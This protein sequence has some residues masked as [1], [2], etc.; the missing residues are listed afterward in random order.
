MADIIINEISQNYTYQIGNSSFC[1]VALPITACW[2]PA[3]ED[4]ASVG[5]SL[6]DELELTQWQKFTA[7]PDGLNSF[8]KTFRGPA[9]NY[10]IAKDF[11]Y[12][13]AMTLLTA[14]YDVLVCR[15]CPGTHAQVTLTDSV[16]EGTFTI[17]AKYPGTFGN[18]LFV[19]L[20]K[21]PNKNYWNLVTYVVD[22]SGARTSAENLTFAFD[23][24][25][26]T[27][28]IMHISEL[29]SSFFTFVV[30][31]N[32]TDAASFAGADTGVV[33]TGGTDRS[34]D[35]TAE[36]MMSNA[37]GLAT[38]R[39]ATVSPTAGTDYIAALNALKATNPDIAKAATVR[40]MEWV[41]TNAI[42]VYKLLDDRL[43]YNPNRIISP[44]WDDQNITEID[45]STPSRISAV[46]PLHAVLLEMS[47][48]SR[49]GA[50]YIDIPKSCPRSAVY[51]ETGDTATAGYAQLLGRY[52]S[53]D[54][55]GDS[56]Y[57]SHAALVAPW[58]QYTYTGTA[59][60]NTCSPSILQLLSEIAE[61][62]GQSLQYEW[63]LPTNKTHNLKIGKLDYSVPKKLM[64]VW[65]KS[66]GIGVNII[67]SIPGQ[68][69]NVWGNS[70]LYDVPPAT[71]QALANLST[72]KLVNAI[73]NVVYQVGITITFQ[74][75][76]NEAYSR[77]YT[78]CS[79]ILD[80][81]KNAGAILGSQITMS[82][83]INGVDN[84]N[85]NGVVGQIEI[86]VAGVINDIKVDLICLPPTAEL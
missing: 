14:G 36:A 6:D 18:S 41:Y 28:S 72:R 76:N 5:I 54:S 84:I 49:C 40:Y 48:K 83:D 64:D 22:A 26:T 71:Y 82:A 66:E 63:I 17:K 16:S 29:E 57:Q 52:T 55:A 8:V 27:D 73:K 79:P 43:M 47:N 51:N 81:M 45:G 65:Q 2:G 19:T 30:S 15:L 9:A 32:I 86:Q 23:I 12:Q 67:S 35:D 38:A 69:I 34:A 24:N 80:T 62:I 56:M 61:I 7:T 3:F 85:A 50:A 68:G 59:K 75:N 70:T 39:Y 46:S 53:E 42:N 33:L 11:S 60:M 58:G 31:G 44:G 25:N 21:V 13:A 4:P 37:I 74:Y 10:R 77:F 1:T 20:N 78:G